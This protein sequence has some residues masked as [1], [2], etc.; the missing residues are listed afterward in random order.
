MAELCG[1]YNNPPITHIC[2]LQK[3]HTGKHKAYGFNKKLLKTW[4]STEKK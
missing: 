3:G 1:E 4:Y 2:N